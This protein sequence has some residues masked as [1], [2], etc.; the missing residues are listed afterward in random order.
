M[1]FFDQ[2]DDHYG[3]D[4]IEYEV[5]D[6]EN[7][8]LP[9]IRSPLSHDDF[10][11]LQNQVDLLRFSNSHGIDIYTEVVQFVQSVLDED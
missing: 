10:E 6:D 5:E 11:H 1:D 9:P 3:E 4:E 7:V 2:V 8:D